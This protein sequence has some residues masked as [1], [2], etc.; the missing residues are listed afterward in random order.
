MRT[1][2]LAFVSLINAR[3]LLPNYLSA[4]EDTSL[5]VQF[6]YESETRIDILGHE[7][8]F[9]NPADDVE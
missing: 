6:H 9:V 4:L 5:K 1:F 3:R 2:S 7:R 8:N